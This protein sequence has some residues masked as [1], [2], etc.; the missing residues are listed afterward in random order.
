M[1]WHS[2]CLSTVNVVV[3]RKTLAG[4]SKKEYKQLETEF[5]TAC[6]AITNLHQKWWPWC[7]RP[8]SRAVTICL[9]QTQEPPRPTACAWKVLAGLARL[10]MLGL[11][12]SE[13]F[14]L[15]NIQMDLFNMT[16]MAQKTIYLMLILEMWNDIVWRHVVSF[17]LLTLKQYSY[18]KFVFQG[19]YNHWIL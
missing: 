4:I 16:F 10:Q 6:W 7:R 17:L 9:Q 5:K 3:D 11:F 2:H 18:R 13:Q 15:W 8:Q 12:F 14:L 19:S 1:L